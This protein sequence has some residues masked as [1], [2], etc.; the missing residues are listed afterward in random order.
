MGSNVA[1]VADL[2]TQF[3]A[4]A[5]TGPVQGTASAAGVFVSASAAS[6]RPHA[7]QAVADGKELAQQ[8]DAYLAGKAHAASRRFAVRLVLSPKPR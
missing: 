4:V 8:V 2:R 5:A 6:A 7:V 3:D 1:S